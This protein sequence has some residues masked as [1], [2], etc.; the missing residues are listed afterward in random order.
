MKIPFSKDDGKNIL[1]TG[2]SWVISLMMF[3]YGA[4]KIQ[5]FRGAIKIDKPIPELSGMEL[6]WAFY[7]YSLPF[8]LIIGALEVTGAL[9]IFFKRTRLI[10]C[11]LTSTI[12]INVILQDFFFDVHIG[13]LFN[14]ISYQLFIL[15]IFWLNRAQII[16]AIKMLSSSIKINHK[17]KKRL[18][19]YALTFLTFAVILTLQHILTSLISQYFN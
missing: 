10:G 6:M 5:Q 12:L 4:A 11:F 14:A 18:T 13:A 2:L 17:G 16:E 8:A 7:D 19:F 9:L 15:I 1:E 3:V